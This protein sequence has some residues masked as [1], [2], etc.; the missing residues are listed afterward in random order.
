MKNIYQEEMVTLD[1][2]DR[3]DCGECGGKRTLVL[4]HR[5]EF[6]QWFDDLEC[7]YCA[8]TLYEGEYDVV[9]DN[10]FNSAS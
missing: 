3:G 7:W 8:N 4:V 2:D 9:R 10:S 1:H 5:L 6:G